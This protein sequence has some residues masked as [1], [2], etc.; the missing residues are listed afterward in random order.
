M[1]HGHT[2]DAFHEEGPSW[3][4]QD[5]DGRDTRA[6]FHLG[7]DPYV[8]RQWPEGADETWRGRKGFG[9]I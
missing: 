2:G 9:S 4:C 6:P 3:K 7:I 1:G 8:P 5:G